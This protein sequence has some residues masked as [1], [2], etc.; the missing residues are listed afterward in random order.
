MKQLS[1]QQGFVLSVGHGTRKRRMQKALAPEG[2]LLPI[3]L[4]LL[5]LM[6]DL[7][8]GMID[9]DAGLLAETV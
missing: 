6:V 5:D 4:D 3:D 9:W 2:V 8:P 1:P 7:D